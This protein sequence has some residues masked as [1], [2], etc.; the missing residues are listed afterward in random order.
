[1]ANATYLE[2]V[3]GVLKRLRED[4]V[5]SVDESSYA[6]LIGIFVNEARREVED[7]WQWNALKSTITVTTVIAQRDY[8]LTASH[9]R[10]RVLEAFNTTKKWRLIDLPDN[11]WI[12][13]LLAVTTVQS[14]SPTHYDYTQ[15][16]TTS[17][18]LTIRLYPLPDA[19]ET[20][21]F[22]T[23]NPQED[24]SVGTEILRIPKDPVLQL[25]HLKAINERG[26]DQGRAAEI[27]ERLYL[28]TLADAISQD[29]ARIPEATVW[30][31]V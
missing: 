28:K 6:E 31:P 22:Y 12:N 10:T 1:M 27:Q 4:T 29:A 24:F 23:I 20:L 26:E 30:V 19:V 17:G 9:S 15:N 13:N 11:S 16:D 2:L 18:A 14:Q 5:S 21:T 25:A 7:A 8:D 3:N